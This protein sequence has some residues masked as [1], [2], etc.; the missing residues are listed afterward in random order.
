MPAIVS[1]ATSETAES[2]GE[3][4]P[5]AEPSSGHPTEGFCRDCGSNIGEFYNSWHRVTGSYF[6][7]A[8]LG[9]YRS[10]LR[11]TGKQKVASKGTD[12]EGW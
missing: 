1:G 4:R 3:S 7:P 8:L 10:L 5:H 6:V 12:L 2:A 11:S 9:S